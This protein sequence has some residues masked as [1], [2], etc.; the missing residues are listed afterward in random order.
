MAVGKNSIAVKMKYVS[1]YCI[2]YQLAKAIKNDSFKLKVG[3]EYK[4]AEPCSKCNGNGII[5]YY[6]FYCDGI[7]FDCLGLGYKG[8]YTLVNI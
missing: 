4:L 7:C 5:P 3:T 2:L 1:P 8:E 6:H